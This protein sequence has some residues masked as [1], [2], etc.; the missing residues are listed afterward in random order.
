M[1]GRKR[2]QVGGDGGKEERRAGEEVQLTVR[3]KCEVFFCGSLGIRGRG[4]EEYN[5]GEGGRVSGRGISLLG[6][7]GEAIRRQGS[8]GKILRI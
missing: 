6:K 7:D 4:E 5:E 2:E 1:E 8:G 3:R